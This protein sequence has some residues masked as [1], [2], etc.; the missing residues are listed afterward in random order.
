MRNIT[1][2]L[3]FALGFICFNACSE[4]D[5]EKIPPV[6]KED[7]KLVTSFKENNH[8]IELYSS[9][10]KFEV[11]YNPI[12]IMVKDSDGAYFEEVEITQF[13]PVMHM[14][15]KQHSC[16][17]SESFIPFTGIA[18]GFAVFLMPSSS[19]EPWKLSF[20]YRVNNTEYHAQNKD[21]QVVNPI[22][23]SLAKGI[24]TDNDKYFIAYM[25]PK[26]P[27]IGANKI[28]AKIFTTEDMYT[29]KEVK[30]FSLKLDPRMPG[31]GNHSSPNNENLLYKG[32]VYEGTVNFSMTGYWKLNLE[33]LNTQ[34]ES[35]LGNSVDDD[36]SE[37]SSSL[38]WEIEF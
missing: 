19:E 5:N 34:G 6:I 2:I 23:P 22:H 25:E 27:T 37:S 28:T 3:F 8:T 17:R 21:I 15:N 24:G 20:N 11:G 9:K 14:M 29:F 26:H 33:L 16:P 35:V 4:D 10:E 7:M 38:Y 32:T 12:E 18:K 31:M 36:N 1:L 13:T 30:N